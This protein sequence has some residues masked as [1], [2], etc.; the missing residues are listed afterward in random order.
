MN[1]LSFSDLRINVLSPHRIKI[2]NEKGSI[3]FELENIIDDFS[4][5]YKSATHEFE[6][7]AI[8]TPRVISLRIALEKLAKIEKP[9]LENKLEKSEG[10]TRTFFKNHTKYI[11][12]IDKR[13]LGISEVICF[14][15]LEFNAVIQEIEKS[16]LEE[17][18]L[19][20]FTG[21]SAIATGIIKANSFRS[22]DIEFLAST[23]FSQS[24]F[25]K[26]RA[27]HFLDAVLSLSKGIERESNTYIAIDTKSMRIEPIGQ[28]LF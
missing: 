18:A 24:I 28:F 5:L 10:N 9:E 17:F 25:R 22:I 27:T 12:G 20:V 2:S 4:A 15:P 21:L 1:Q 19:V 23:E 7:N 13:K 16:D 14:S 26:E 8:L 3:Y 11:F 6:D